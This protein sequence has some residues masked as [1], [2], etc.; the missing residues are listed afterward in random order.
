[1]ASP[2]SYGILRTMTSQG[3]LAGSGEYFGIGIGNLGTGAATPWRYTNGA[4]MQQLGFHP[5]NAYV[6]PFAPP[7]PS[8]ADKCA[9]IDEYHA[10]Q[11]WDCSNV[12]QTAVCSVL[13]QTNS[14]CPA[15]SDVSFSGSCYKRFTTQKSA[16][17]AA[18][19]CGALDGGAT[20]AALTSYSEW[21]ELGTSGTPAHVGFS[22][23][24]VPGSG[25]TCCNGDGQRD[26]YYW[27]TGESAGLVRW[28]GGQQN[29]FDQN[30]GI[31]DNVG[32]QDRPCSATEEFVCEVRKVSPC[33][34]GWS[35]IQ[36]KDNHVTGTQPMCYLRHAT[37]MS[38]SAATA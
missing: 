3:W 28:R 11:E 17:D 13:P 6:H 16:F 2:T 14:Q 24:G 10:A 19:H 29:E 33:P 20:L 7:S 36:T 4:P 38:Y 12:A 34:V 1:M 30:C 31:V 37:V 32:F 9:D 15:W 26:Q 35:F 5:L 27:V 25:T 21:L 23:L 22:D 8:G 18:A